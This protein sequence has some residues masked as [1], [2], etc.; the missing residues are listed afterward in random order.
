MFA[1]ATDLNKHYHMCAIKMQRLAQLQK[2]LIDVRATNQC[3][4]SI[5]RRPAQIL[6]VTYQYDF[7]L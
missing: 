2:R 4:R 1:I 6:L 5:L 3:I 7:A